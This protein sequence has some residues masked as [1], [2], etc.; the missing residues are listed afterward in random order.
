MNGSVP[1]PPSR[2]PLDFS[3]YAFDRKRACTTSTLACPNVDR[4][5]GEA[6]Q[7]L[8]YM[9]RMIPGPQRKRR[10]LEHSVS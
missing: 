3:P 5:P 8:N 2:V 4:A 10:S 9:L 1:A 7:P 6:T